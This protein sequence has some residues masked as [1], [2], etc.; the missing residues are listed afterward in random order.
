[1]SSQSGPG[2]QIRPQPPPAPCSLGLLPDQMTGELR[3]IVGEHFARRETIEAPALKDL[4]WRASQ[5]GGILVESI[6]RWKPE[7]LGQRPAVII[8][9]NDWTATRILQDDRYGST[10]QAEPIYAV[11]MQGSHT[12]FCLAKAGE[13]AEVLGAEVLRELRGFSKQVR[14]ELALGRFVVMGL[15]ELFQLKEATETFAVPVTVAYAAT[16]SWTVHEHA[17][18]LRRIE[19]SAAGMRP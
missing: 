2:P 11:I 18:R 13:E 3:H 15:G 19:L 4:L 10:P 7:E 5:V 1:M 17:P 12:L 8:K 6:A 9:R 14:I 16:E